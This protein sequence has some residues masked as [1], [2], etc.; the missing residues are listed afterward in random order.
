MQKLIELSE[1][2]NNI[3]LELNGLWY[4]GNEKL[5]YL[6]L[7]IN[8]ILQ[9]NKP[10]NFIINNPYII[11]LNEIYYKFKNFIIGQR[12]GDARYRD[13]YLN[14][15][16]NIHQDFRTLYPKNLENINYYFFSSFS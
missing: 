5:E 16:K 1:I 2:N 15:I 3:D 4:S 11:Q 12:N 8:N 9:Y 6:D 14:Y 13:I 10:E 7:F